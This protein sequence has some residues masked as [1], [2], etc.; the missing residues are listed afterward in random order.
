[1]AFVLS[2]TAIPD[3]MPSAVFASESASSLHRATPGAESDE[4]ELH[5]LLDRQASDLPEPDRYVVAN[6]IC[7]SSAGVN[8]KHQ[9]GSEGL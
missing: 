4:T 5:E 9:R 8:E 1:V 2:V 6:P 3:Q 7:H